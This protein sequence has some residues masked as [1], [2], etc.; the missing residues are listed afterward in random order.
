MRYDVRLKNLRALR[1]GAEQER[2]GILKA[3]RGEVAPSGTYVR[4]TTYEV[5]FGNLARV[6][7]GGGAYGRL[8]ICKGAW[9]VRRYWARSCQVR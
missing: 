5:R 7:R 6:A 4:S 3:V 2:R 8:L 1:G 9:R